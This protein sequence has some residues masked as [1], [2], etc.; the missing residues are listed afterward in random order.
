MVY[1][2][3]KGAGGGGGDATAFNQ[4]L[5]IEQNSTIN[6]S[7]VIYITGVDLLDLQNNVTSFLNTSIKTLQSVNTFTFIDPSTSVLVFCSFIIYK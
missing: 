2:I 4:Q 6:G 7:N 1:I 5:Q 3:K